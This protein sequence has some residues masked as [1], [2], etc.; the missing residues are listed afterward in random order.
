MA[1][2]ILPVS[3]LPVSTLPV[4]ILGFARVAASVAKRVRSRVRGLVH[5]RSWGV[6]G[7]LVLALTLAGL[8]R[9]HALQPSP[10]HN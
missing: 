8:A 7:V 5:P 10:E 9:A 3:I 6:I 2:S 1:V 4:S